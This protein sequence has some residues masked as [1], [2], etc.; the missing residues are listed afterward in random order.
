MAVRSGALQDEGFLSQAK[1]TYRHW[2]SYA[3][4]RFFGRWVQRLLLL[5]FLLVLLELAIDGKWLFFTDKL[6]PRPTGVAGELESLL[7]GADGRASL[8]DGELPFFWKH[9]FLT[10]RNT[11]IGFVIGSVVGLTLAIVIVLYP[12]SKSVVQ[13]SVVGFEAV[14]KILLIPIIFAWFGFGGT[15]II[16][17]TILITFFPVF[18]SSLTGMVNV[19]E[20][21]QRLLASYQAN[22]VQR[23][24]MSNIPR[25]IPNI[26][27]GLKIGI[28]NSMIGTILAEFIFGNQGLGFL[29]DLFHNQLLLER[30]WA[31]IVAV[32]VTFALVFWVLEMVQRYVAFWEKTPEEIIQAT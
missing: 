15:S 19:P 32:A 28:A 22:R 29:V 6:L 2:A 26:F 21:D 23:L 9:W 13:D 24:Y 8:W 1:R 10:V 25:S 3:V 4:L 20:D 31:G 17:L 18:V 7:F 12:F 5:S 11:M 27:A 30:E 14:P 16:V